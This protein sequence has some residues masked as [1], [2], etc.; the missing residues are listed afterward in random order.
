MRRW[1]SLCGRKA[2]PPHPFKGAC[3]AFRFCTATV[4]RDPLL[5]F[6]R[7]ELSRPRD[8]VPCRSAVADRVPH[9]STMPA[10]NSSLEDPGTEGRLVRRFRYTNVYAAGLVLRQWVRAR[11][12]WSVPPLA[13]IESQRTVETAGAPQKQYPGT[14]MLVY[15]DDVA[16][17]HQSALIAQLV[18]RRSDKAK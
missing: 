15:I 16:S 11:S 18:A 10:R 17:G 9:S 7:G 1:G 2:G 13:P 14:V 5:K 3:T 8:L 12:D 4:Q 6:V